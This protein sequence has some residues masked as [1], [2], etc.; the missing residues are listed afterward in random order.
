[1]HDLAACFHADGVVSAD[2]VAALEGESAAANQPAEETVSMTDSPLVRTTTREENMNQTVQQLVAELAALK[3]VLT[4]ALYTTPVL[5]G[6]RYSHRWRCAPGHGVTDCRRRTC[7]H[8]M[9]GLC[10]HSFFLP[11]RRSKCDRAVSTDALQRK[12]MV[13]KT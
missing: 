6:L 11:T 4:T 5:A 3:Q 2:I 13:V 7:F 10:H 9:N 12:L 8:S 1:M